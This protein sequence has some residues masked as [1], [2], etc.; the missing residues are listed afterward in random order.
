MSIVVNAVVVML[1]LGENPVIIRGTFFLSVA[2]GCCV[3]AAVGLLWVGRAKKLEA[4]T[5]RNVG[6]NKHIRCVYNK[7]I[8]IVV[9]YL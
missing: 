4:C 2:V 3:L 6:K 8:Y 9:S 7:I 1:I 5:E